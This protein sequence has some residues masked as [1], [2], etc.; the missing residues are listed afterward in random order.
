MGTFL[1]SLRSEHDISDNLAMNLRSRES[2]YIIIPVH[3]RKNITLKCLET[4]K[5]CGDLNRYYTVVVDDGSTDGTSEAITN[6]YPEVTILTGDGNLWWTGA[7]RK[8]MEY[9]YEQGAEYLIW[10]NDDCIVSN[11]TL[12]YL[13]QVCINNKKAIIG[14][15]GYFSLD[16]QEIAFGGKLRTINGYQFRKFPETETNP[17]DLLS[18]NIVCFSKQVILE[19][20]YPD[21]SATPHY[22]GDSLYLIRARNAGFKIFVDTHY[23]VFDIGSKSQLFPNRWLF[24]EGSPL[25]I[26]KMVFNHQSYLNWKIWLKLETEDYQL[27]GLLTFSYKYFLKIL[28]PV[29]IITLLRFLPYSFRKKISMLKRKLANQL[30]NSDI[31]KIESK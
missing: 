14:C 30:S 26:L 9:A 22:G 2:V 24:Q 8:G 29:I 5:Q 7:I 25:H 20:G 27:L 3:N 16:N 10:L 21:F 18:G 19:I 13:V 15:Q 4:L 11:G 23:L 6:L 17:C 28:I 1:G 31:V 12:F